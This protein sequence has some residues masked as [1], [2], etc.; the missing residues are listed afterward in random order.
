MGENCER[1][2]WRALYKTEEH[3]FLNLNKSPSIK[4]YKL[5]KTKNK[6]KAVTAL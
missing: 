1:N 2:N 3:E 4:H 6:W 5:E